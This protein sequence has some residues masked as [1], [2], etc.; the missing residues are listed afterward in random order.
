M[1][2]FQPEI[3][4][5]PPGELEFGPFRLDVTART[6]YRGGECV[7]LRP[8]AFAALRVLVEFAGQLVTKEEILQRVWPATFVAEGS[9]TN[10]ISTL[11]TL[12]NPH[13]EGDGPIATIS[14]CG[15]RFTAPVQVRHPQPETGIVAGTTSAA[16]ARANIKL[17][18]AAKA[19]AT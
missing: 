3:V 18:F 8:K 15:Y 7:P 11:R 6:L 16:A 10:I 17:A 1:L 19:G 13:F 9:I 4:T 14:G 2:R 5:I 12:L